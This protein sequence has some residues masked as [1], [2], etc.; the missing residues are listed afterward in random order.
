MQE[1]LD[2]CAFTRDKEKEPHLLK[3]WSPI[4][5]PGGIDDESSLEQ[6]WVWG[7]HLEKSALYSAPGLVPAGALRRRAER[8]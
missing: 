8:Y 6:P 1:T 5:E 7:Q 4:W 2:T 3:P